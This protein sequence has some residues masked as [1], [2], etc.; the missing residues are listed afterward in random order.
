VNYRSQFSHVFGIEVPIAV[1][2]FAAVAVV[3]VFAVVARRAGRGVEASQK[4]KYSKVEFAYAAAVFGMAVF[5]VVMTSSANTVEQTSVGKPSLTV[6]VHAFQWCWEFAYPQSGVAVGG[7]CLSGDYPT[8][9]LPVGRTVEMEV[10]S[11]DV[12]HEWWVPY[13]RYKIEAFPDHW[14]HFLL[15]LDHTGQWRGRCSEFCGL[16]HDT[17]FFSVRGVPGAVFDQWLA[18]H[19]PGGT[20]P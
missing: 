15:R 10:T 20:S 14:N 8:L 4:P 5:L 9:V 18:S 12:V 11:Q 6:Q 19:A 1:A 17:M 7:N 2:V 16:Y 13:L 3:L